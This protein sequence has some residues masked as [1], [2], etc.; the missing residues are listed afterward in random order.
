LTLLNN[1]NITK[2]LLAEFRRNYTHPGKQ[3]FCVSWR[4]THLFH[5]P[6]IFKT[7]LFAVKIYGETDQ[8]SA[9]SDLRITDLHL[10]VLKWERKPMQRYNFLIMKSI[11]QNIFFI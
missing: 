5:V 2:K 9:K 3:L 8:V 4:A 6:L 10:V 11:H 1:L 7:L